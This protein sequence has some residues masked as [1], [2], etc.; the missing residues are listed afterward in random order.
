MEIFG[1]VHVWISSNQ[2]AN[3]LLADRGTIYSDRPTI[4]NLP[5]NRTSGDYLPL[6]GRNETWK[7][8]RKFAH[9]VMTRS[10]AASQHSYPTR[11]L[12][13]L[14]YNILQ[15]PSN[16]QFL[17]EEQTG[18]TISRLAWG[19][20]EHQPELKDDTQALL[21]AISPSGAVPNVVSWLTALPHWLSPWKMNEKQRHAKEK[22]FF[23]HA[24]RSTE[25]AIERGIA[26]PSYMKMFLEGKDKKENGW[27]DEE[28]IYQVGM[29]AIAGALTMASPMMS[30]IIAMCHYPEWQTKLQDELET[31]LGGRCLGWEDRDSLPIL[32]AVVKEVLRWRPPVPTGIPHRLEKDDIYNGYFIPAG[33]TIHALEWGISR[34]QSVYPD[35]EAFRPERWLLPSYPSFKC[36]TTLKGYHQFGH[37]RRVCQGIDIVEQELFLV[38]GGLAWAF[39]ISKKRD[40]DGS[41][42]EVP[43]AKYTSLLIAKPEHFEFDLRVRDQERESII[44]AAWRE[45]DYSRATDAEVGTT[46]LSLKEKRDERI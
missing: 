2:I 41:E 37:G 45:V 42:I 4:P 24:R 9:H 44:E 11:E 26:E 8:Q 27:H 36:G 32:R 7:R 35:P 38:M 39:D 29:L 13:R 34:D 10:A 5:D 1:S 16:Y 22:I 18:R 21:A 40:K 14:L 15:D 17:L 30:Y 6:L 25:A 12:K 31:V 33:A 46:D 43:L 20:P 19:A 3:D 23:A 28:G